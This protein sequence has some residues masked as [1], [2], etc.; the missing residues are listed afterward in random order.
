[1]AVR[2]RVTS[3]G[4]AR[5][6]F[7]ANAE[8]MLLTARTLFNDEGSPVIPGGVE[9]WKNLFIKHPHGEYDGRLT[10][11]ASSLENL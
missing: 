8:L 4:P 7:R 6:V 11:S 5:P 9:P 2:G 1:M 10:E 3:P